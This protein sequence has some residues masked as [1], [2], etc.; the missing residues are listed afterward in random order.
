MAFHM[1]ISWRELMVTWIGDAKFLTPFASSPLLV[2]LTVPGSAIEDMIAMPLLC[3]L[4]ARSG[5][6]SFFASV[7]PVSS[8]CSHAPMHTRNQESRCNVRCGRSRQAPMHANADVFE[9]MR[10]AAESIQRA[11][12]FWAY[13]LGTEGPGQSCACS[14]KE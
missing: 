12:K 11:T 10:A 1:P 7:A 9:L 8:L 14:S 4:T 13:L 5:R 6:D 2:F 3:E